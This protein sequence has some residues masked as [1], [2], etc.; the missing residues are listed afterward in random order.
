MKLLS[1]FWAQYTYVI[2]RFPLNN[3][4]VGEKITKELKRIQEQL[5]ATDEQ[6]KS[7]R[8]VLELIDEQ[9]DV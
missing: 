6:M 8:E 2:F 7:F 1:K 3:E 9:K 5:K 4:K